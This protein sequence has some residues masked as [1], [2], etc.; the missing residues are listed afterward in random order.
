MNVTPD[1]IET[2]LELKHEKFKGLAEKRTNKAL[3]SI[4][5]IGNLSNRVIYRYEEQEIRKIIKALHLAVSDVE[6]R[7]KSTDGEVHGGFTL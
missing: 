4:R 1:T 6:A 7:F 3:T 5:L 2:P